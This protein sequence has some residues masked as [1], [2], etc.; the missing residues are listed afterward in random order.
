MTS[1]FDKCTYCPNSHLETAA[2]MEV[3]DYPEHLKAMIAE[4][5]RWEEEEKRREQLERE[6]CKVH[7]EGEG[8]ACCVYVYACV[9]VCKHACV[10]YV[11]L[12]F[13]CVC[14]HVYVSRHVCI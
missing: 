5:E 6:M 8:L 3:E 2:V 11:A 1:S 12:A 9:R 4:E 7:L 13:V 14:V 10:L